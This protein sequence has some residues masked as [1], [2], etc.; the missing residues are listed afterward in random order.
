MVN[1]S[2][3]QSNGGSI[4]KNIYETTVAEIVEISNGRIDVMEILKRR[5]SNVNR[6]P[7]SGALKIPETAPAAPHPRRSVIFLYESPI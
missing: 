1:D 7:A 2:N 3:S 5:I 4:P 6:T